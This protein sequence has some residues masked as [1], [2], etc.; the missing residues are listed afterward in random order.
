MSVCLGLCGEGEGL[1]WWGGVLSLPCFCAGHTGH[2]GTT[3]LS[4]R[5]ME[6]N[7]RTTGTRKWFGVE[8]VTSCL[9]AIQE[10]VGDT[11]NIKAFTLGLDG[12]GMR[13]GPQSLV[14]E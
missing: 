6:W 12:G 5:M 14:P 11:D 3:P 13:K 10:E 1:V 4:K 7:L 9:N 2:Y 8:R